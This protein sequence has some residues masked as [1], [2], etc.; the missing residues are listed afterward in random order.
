MRSALHTTEAETLVR[1]DQA[2]VFVAIGRLVERL[3]GGMTEVTMSDPPRLLTHTVTAEL[4]SPD[5]DAWLTWEVTASAS[6]S[7]TRLRLVHDE[8]DLSPG[9]APELDIVLTLLHDELELA[10]AVPWEME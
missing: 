1:A 4:G 7:W 6:A 9:P 8:A 10:S 2:M 3:W 5:V